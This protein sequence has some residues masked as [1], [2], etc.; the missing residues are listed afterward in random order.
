MPVIREK[1]PSPPAL[2][3]ARLRSFR[4]DRN[5]G[6]GAGP[7]KAGQAQNAVGCERSGHGSINHAGGKLASNCSVS[8]PIV[9]VEQ[10]VAEDKPAVICMF[11]GANRWRVV[12]SINTRER[13]ALGKGVGRIEVSWKGSV[14]WTVM[15]QL[16]SIWSLPSRSARAFAGKVPCATVPKSTTAMRTFCHFRMYTPLLDNHAPM[17]GNLNVG[18][19]P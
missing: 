5:T 16:P 17:K 3:N 9:E 14:T 15:Y 4:W 2:K 8:D 11:P 1:P 13:T 7:V 10:Y 18:R 19:V 12:S 6:K